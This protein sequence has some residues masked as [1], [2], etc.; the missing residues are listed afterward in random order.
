MSSTTCRA[1]A[2]WLASGFPCPCRNAREPSRLPFAASPKT[3]GTTW[4][5][6]SRARKRTRGVVRPAAL[7][8]RTC[9]AGPVDHPAKE[10][11]FYIREV[12]LWGLPD[13]GTAAPASGTI[14]V[15][16]SPGAKSVAAAYDLKL[17]LEQMTGQTWPISSRE[18]PKS[19]RCLLV[20]PEA[21]RPAGEDVPQGPW[22][23]SEEILL[24]SKGDWLIVAG[25]DAGGYQGTAFAATL[26]L[27]KL[28]CGWYGPDPLWQV[29]PRT[30]YLEFPS[31]NIRQRPSLAFRQMWYSPGQLPV[32][33][34]QGG[35]T[36]AAGHAHDA[37][38]PPAEYFQ[39]HPEYFA[40]IGG[41]R[42]GEGEWQ[43]C[44]SHADVVC[45]TAEK[46]RAWFAQSPGNAAFS[47]SNNDC[48][49][50]CECPECARTGATLA[51]H[52]NLCECRSAGD[53]SNAPGPKGVFSRLLVHV[54]APPAGARAEPGVIV[55][56]VNQAC[57]AH[58]LDDP[59]CEANAGWCR[60]L[61]VD[62]P[63]VPKWRSMSGTSRAVLPLRENGLRGSAG[64]R[65][66]ATCA[67][68]RGTA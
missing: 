62:A 10:W 31:L 7:H 14:V 15:G 17:H 53:P 32:R 30:G 21:A 49:G 34:L 65:P 29:I 59:A 11:G 41:R 45:I 20:G 12:E 46:A 44:T 36:I 51:A 28:G 38:C 9:P 6:S 2:A 50:F 37:I 57:H 55:M 64:T 19:G 54:W 27:E 35:P 42:K 5:K 24:K 25:N 66:H 22:P 13:D 52:V 56:V 48:G 26:L 23:T 47:L 68:G 61:K 63:P 39:T 8:P 43:L 1:F 60:N 58:A 33:W 3:N 40:L 16:S 67:I 18:S 4:G